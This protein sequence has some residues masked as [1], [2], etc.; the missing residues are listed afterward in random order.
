VDLVANAIGTL[1]AG[2]LLDR[3]GFKVIQ[4]NAAAVTLMIPM[5]YGVFEGLGHSL[6]GDFL[7]TMVFFAVLGVAMGFAVLPSTRGF[8]SRWSAPLASALPTTS[9]M[10]SLAASP[11]W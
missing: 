2:H 3:P 8:T 6:V 10:A 5:T 4:S 11:P 1:L 9:A 7:L